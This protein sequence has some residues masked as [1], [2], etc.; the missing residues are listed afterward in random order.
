[1]YIC[2]LPRS[3]VVWRVGIPGT[4][5]SGTKWFTQDCVLW[6]ESWILLQNCSTGIISVSLQT[7][8]SNDEHCVFVL[9]NTLGRITKN[10][11]WPQLHITC[12]RCLPRLKVQLTK[13]IALKIWHKHAHKLWS[14]VQFFPCFASDYNY[15]GGNYWLPY[16]QGSW[17]VR[18]TDRS[19]LWSNASFNHFIT[20][21]F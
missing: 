11:L 19:R 2:L 9:L 14:W 1:M 10:G 13:V 18:L 12:T 7:E 6:L 4:F 21:L 17:W 8:R 16:T 20:I 15:P 5:P 3:S